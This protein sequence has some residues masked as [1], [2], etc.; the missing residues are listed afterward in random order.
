MP[1]RRFSA[2]ALITAMVISGPVFAD[3]KKAGLEIA[4]K[5]DAANQGF[6]SESSVMEMKLINAYGDVT[7]RRMLSQVLEGTNEGDLSLATFEWPADVKG[8]KCLRTR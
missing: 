1:I 7:T 8:T 3:A 2:L 6:K 4:L 5:N